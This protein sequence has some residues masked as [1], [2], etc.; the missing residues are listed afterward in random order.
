MKLFDVYP[1]YNVTP[2]KAEGCYVWDENNIKYLD[3]YGGHGVIS[4]G[5]T[6]PK[7]VA[8]LTNQLQKIGFYSNSVQMPLQV[9]LAEKLGKLSS[10]ENYNLFLCNSGAEANENALKLASFI[11]GKSRI[12]AFTN[13]FHGRT[14]AAV[15]VTDNKSINAPINLQQEVT[16]LPLNDIELVIHELG[17]GDV[18]AVII[19]GIQGVGG[20]D[21]GTKKFFKKVKKICKKK[22]VILILD[23]IQ[24]G[25][26]RSG[27]FFAFQHHNIKPDIITIAKGMA[28]GFPIGGVL[29]AKKHKAKYGMLG[30]TFGGNHLACVAAISV[31]DI[32][33]EEN[34]ISNVNEVSN[35]FMEEIKQI[36]EVKK[37]KGKGLMLGV[38][39]DF[40]VGELRKK[41]IFDKHIFTGGSNNKNLLRILPPLTITKAQINEFIKALKEVLAS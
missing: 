33:E 21:E 14:S 41:L 10:C 15:A 2:V 6:H 1:L 31:L 22:E 18:A 12:L 28:N 37:V 38:E 35:Y 34:L 16:F 24:S 23:E 4:V 36:S 32:I 30:T 29:I 7:Y 40:E 8:S 25:Y 3:L 13:S 9:E 39:F 26:G 11:T 20:L 27:Q 17:K 5:H 19:E